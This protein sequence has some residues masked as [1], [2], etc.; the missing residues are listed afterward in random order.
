MIN[1]NKE[2][3]NTACSHKNIRWMN[4]LCMIFGYKKEGI[5]LDCG[6]KL[7]KDAEGKIVEK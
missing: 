5:C 6:K 7:F 3:V 1:M 2:K 4:S